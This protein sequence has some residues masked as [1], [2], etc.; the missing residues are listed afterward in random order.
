M[1]FHIS[2]RSD[3][4]FLKLISKIPLIIV[5]FLFKVDKNVQ[6]FLQFSVKYKWDIPFHSKTNKMNIIF[7]KY[8]GAVFFKP[9]GSLSETILVK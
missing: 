3:V 7:D 1:K 6:Y 5:N 9:R 2:E 4:T 8:T